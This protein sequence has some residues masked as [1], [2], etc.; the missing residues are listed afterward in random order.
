[1]SLCNISKDYPPFFSRGGLEFL[2]MAM[3]KQG[4][5]ELFRI[6]KGGCQSREVSLKQGGG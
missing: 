6:L 5:S 2:N 1:M 4:G 3:N